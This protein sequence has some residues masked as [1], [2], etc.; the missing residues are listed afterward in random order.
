MNIKKGITL[1]EL[2]VAMSITAILSICFSDCIKA[3]STYNNSVINDYSENSVL[4]FINTCKEYCYFRKTSGLV[5]FDFVN[6][7]L[8]FYEGTE[9]KR[10]WSFPKG[11][12]LSSV[13]T[14]S[15]NINAGGFISN[16]CTIIYKDRTKANHYITVSVGTGYVEIKD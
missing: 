5:R 12:K 16:A 3:F 13:N 15:L 4:S 8:D 1:I 2:L 11:F 7:K 6:S 14:E 9:R 10:M